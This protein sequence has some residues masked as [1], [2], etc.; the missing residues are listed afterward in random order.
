[1][2]QT[3]LD[4]I[5]KLAE[6]LVFFRGNRAAFSLLSQHGI[7]TRQRIAFLLAHKSIFGVV[8]QLLEGICSRL[9]QALDINAP[10]GQLGR[11][12]R[13]LP[14][15][16]NRQAELIFHHN[17]RGGLSA[18][19][20][21][22]QIYA[23]NTRRAERL[24]N[25]RSRVGIVFNHIN[26]FVVQLAHDRLDA[27]PANAHACAHRVH[28]R[29]KRRH[30]YLRTLA[31]LSG[32]RA[33]LYQAVIDLG[34]LIFQQA[35]QE[36]AMRTRQHNLRAA[37]RLLHFQEQRLHPVMNTEALA[38]D[39]LITRQNPLGLHIQAQGGSLRRSS[40]HHPADDF[41]YLLGIV[42]EL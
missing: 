3:T 33:D 21:L 30:G 40:L 36:V 24:G 31:R 6:N 10:T 41:A 8:A 37:R 32:N 5:N 17:H 2:D 19:G 18:L 14:I 20:M 15:P 22:I 25:V 4:T 35:A 29:L 23:G 28:R 34:H 26:L 16:A 13:I 39:L 9:D 38:G 1:M 12:A 7:N 27:H 11:Q 42:L